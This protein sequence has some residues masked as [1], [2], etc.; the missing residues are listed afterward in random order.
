MSEPR[1]GR[2]R[3]RV[4]GDLVCDRCG[5]RTTALPWRW[6]DGRICRICYRTAAQTYGTCHGCN[7]DRLVPGLDVD[8]NPLCRSCAGINAKL[9]CTACGAEGLLEKAG[10]CIRCT[11][12]GDLAGLLRPD[13]HPQAA[14]LIDA[15]CSADRPASI[16]TWLRGPAAGLLTGLGD[17]SIGY[18]HDAFDALQPDRAAEHLRA[19]LV[20]A[21]VLPDEHRTAERLQQWLDIKIADVPDGPDRDLVRQFATWHHL[22]LIRR[23]GDDRD[24]AFGSYIAAKQSITETIRFLAWLRDR[25]TGPQ[26]ATQADLDTWLRQHRTHQHVDQ[27]VSWARRT[28]R[29]PGLRNRF[30]TKTVAVMTDEDRRRHIRTLIEDEG[31]PLDL[32]AAGLIVLVYGTTAT[33]VAGLPRSAADPGPPTT[34]R[35][36]D[37]PVPVPEPVA[38]VLRQHLEEHRVSRTLAGTTDHWLFPGS[39][40]GLHLHRQTLTLKLQQHGIPI[41]AARNRALQ[42]LVTTAPPPVVADLLGYHPGTVFRHHEQAAGRYNRYAAEAARALGPSVTQ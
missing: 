9:D 23:H 28:G 32:R 33:T 36:A 30:P 6:P 10:L 11:L 22:R 3:P 2:G 26:Q 8:G 17:G 7:A 21:G 38:A 15:L 37:T 19:I 14:P 16:R 5:R 20:Q 1:R 31:L 42:H 4:E 24:A 40:P 29:L 13:R 41:R 39:R 12:R 35:L 27:F 25:G 34:L 18:T